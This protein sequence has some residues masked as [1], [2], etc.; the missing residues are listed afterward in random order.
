MIKIK[1]LRIKILSY[2]FWYAISF[3]YCI[4]G[5]ASSI[6]DNHRI[7]PDENDYVI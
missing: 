7:H 6:A 4:S 3:D 5:H 2:A 1:K